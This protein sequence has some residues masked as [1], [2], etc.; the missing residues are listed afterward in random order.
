MSGAFGCY[1]LPAVSSSLLRSARLISALTLLSRVL[2]LFRDMAMAAAFGITPVKS[3]FDVAFQIPN[4]FRRLFGEGA[5]S[6]ASIPVL[7]ETLSRQG[8][9]PMDAL[10]GKLLAA[11]LVLLTVL[12]VAG[13]A[14]VAGLYFYYG[15]ES[16]SGF[17]LALTALMLPYLVFICMAALVGGVQNVMGRFASAA[18]APVILNVFMIGATLAAP[19]VVEGLKPQI[20]LVSAVVVVSGVFQAAWQWWAAHRCGLRLPLR[21]EPRDPAL[22]RIGITMLPMIAGLATVQLNTFADS[23]ISWWFVEDRAGPAILA[24]AQRLYQFPL[25]VFATAL[26]TA[27]FP[28]L[29]RHAAEN[30]QAG[31]SATLARGLRVASFEGVPCMV[32]LILVRE[33]LVETLFNYGRFAESPDAVG[34]VS[35]ALLMYGLGIWAF[36]V[37]QIVVRAFYARGDSTTPLRISVRNV[38]LNLVLNLLLV[39]TALRESGLALATTICAVLQVVLLLRAC[40]RATPLAW[41]EIGGSVARTLVATAMMAAAVLLAGAALGDA[42]PK[43]RLVAMVGAGVVGFLPAAWLLRCAELREA[44]KR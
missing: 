30:D 18:S 31:M 34:R 15:G 22:R 5:L 7:S 4:L 17:M 12:C 24:N 36:G 40:A 23:L 3:A 21:L 9:E 43:L 6:A 16:D 32:G 19:R 10:A 13:E 27:I 28:A 29:S 25:G 39:Q 2:G 1:C 41:R 37:N 44:V 11:L 38:F 35:A 26:A 20:V 33:P 14:V 8:R 42:G